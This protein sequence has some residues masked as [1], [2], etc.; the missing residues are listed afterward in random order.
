MAEHDG[1]FHYKAFI[2][3]SHVNKAWGEWLHKAIE[4]YVIPRKLVGTPGRDGPVP[5]RLF[6]VFRDREELPSSHDLGEQISNALK[7]SAYLI[8]ICSPDSANS[9]WVN[10]E[11]L[12]YKRLG[13]ENRVLALIIDG[14]PNATD[15]G[16]PQKECFPK[17]LRFGIGADG[18][19]NDVQQ[20]PIAADVR[21]SG[22]G[23]Q[24]ALLKILAGLLGVSFDT[25]AQRDL[26]RRKARFR[27]AVLGTVA[28]V[29]VVGAGAGY[30][31][32]EQAPHMAYYHTYTTQFGIPEGVGRLSETEASHMSDV[33]AITTQKG[34]V[35]EMQFQNGLFNPKAVEGN[36]ATVDADLVGIA[37][38]KID[39]VG[40]RG[41]VATL[42]NADGTAQ[43]VKE[44]TYSD[45]DRTTATVALKSPGGGVRTLDTQAAFIADAVAGDDTTRARSLITQYRLR[46]DSRGRTRTR[47]F[48]TAM[49]DPAADTSGS[50]GNA[51]DYNGAGL[52]VA[53]RSLD[54]GGK[55]LPDH[56]GIAETHITYSADNLP[57]VAETF[58]DAHHLT[59]NEKGVAR[60]VVARDKRGNMTETRF[61]GADG[62]PALYADWNA[63][64]VAYET[65][66]DGLLTGISF[67]GLDGKPTL[68]RQ[69]GEARATVTY[70]AEGHPLVQSFFGVDG[71]PTLATGAGIAGFRYEYND[72]GHLTSQTFFGVDGKPT[73]SATDGYARQIFTLDDDGRA[74][75]QAYFDAVGKP[76]AAKASGAARITRIYDANGH[77]IAE[78]YFGPD[79]KPAF[80]RVSGVARIRYAYD[81]AGNVIQE[82]Y[83][84]TDG[85][86]MLCADWGA[87]RVTY[88]FDSRGNIMQID[89]FGI[90]GKPIVSA[91]L[92][93]FRAAFR[94][95]DGGHQTEVAYF[96]A[97]EK[98]IAL[99]NG[100]ARETNAYDA[101]GNRIERALFGPDGRPVINRDDGMAV[102]RWTYDARGRATQMRFFGADGRLLNVPQAGFARIDIGYDARGNRTS[103]AYFGAHD[104]P[105]V[106][107]DDGVWKGVL[108]FDARGNVT[109]MHYFGIDG[110][111]A[112]NASTGSAVVLKTYDARSQLVGERYLG[113]DGKP[114]VSRVYGY[115][116]VTRRFDARGNMLEESYTD[117]VGGP[118]ADTHYGAARVVNVFDLRG[119]AIAWAYYGVDGKPVA[120]RINGVARYEADYDGL[121]HAVSV[122]AFGIDGKLMWHK[123]GAAAQA[124][125]DAPV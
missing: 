18:K 121:D 34:R 73:T 21:G 81:G 71:K 85:Q 20:E 52:A 102:V 43:G 1:G 106:D 96:G 124:F 22:D 12:A 91:I 45:G 99:K 38:V 87:A 78:A 44:F 26:Q 122:R 123:D 110:R 105:V 68:N 48:L 8:V 27:N 117:I 4:T 5:K 90:D 29:A 100:V 80:N 3:Y 6:P 46:F 101:R 108:S 115:A 49:G 36:S 63:A 50:Y 41:F 64:R 47:T 51:Y 28:G 88:R 79:G 25:L 114:M 33:V 61:Y 31:W 75:S 19:S 111:P 54:A 32:Y 107:R 40:T 77:T 42:Y 83:F 109:E 120:N 35:V 104:E 74:I 17:A 69:S 70:D 14:D 37:D 89:N 112:I 86:P 76:I 23:K 125:L 39:Y 9:H 119:N 94:Y 57:L 16:H 118:I 93:Y 84:G 62:Q 82:S 92:Y 60:T 113:V 10:E 59:F 30:V 11:I 56:A 58:D 66:D 72:K 55:P 97:D 15:K 53:M 67:F 24:K 13:R 98:P 116:A 103:E 65:N 2:S 7:Q 95:D